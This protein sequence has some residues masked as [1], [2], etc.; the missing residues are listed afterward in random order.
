MDPIQ[1]FLAKLKEHLKD[2]DDQ[3]FMDEHPWCGNTDQ[4]F[5][6]EYSFNVDK[7]LA[8]I[9]DFAATFKK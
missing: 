7:L 4:G 2:C 9:D 8:E 3:E 5:H 1:E 6:T